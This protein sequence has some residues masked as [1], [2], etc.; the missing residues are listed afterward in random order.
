MPTDDF[1]PSL[2][3]VGAVLAYVELPVPAERLAENHEAYVSPLG[4]IR[5]AS[6][7]GLGETRPAVGFK[8][9]WD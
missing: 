3:E 5:K 6:T 4:L 1:T 9:S 8:A 2:D 7:P